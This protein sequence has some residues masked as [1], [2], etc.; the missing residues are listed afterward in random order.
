MLKN[1]HTKF[2][3]KL[4]PGDA[5][6]L[7]APET[8]IFTTD[9]SCL[10]AEPWAVVRPESEAQVVELLKWAQ[11]EKVP[12]FPR[13]RASNGIGGVVPRGGGVVVS[14]LRMNRIVEIGE[15]DFLAVVEPGVVTADLQKAVA[16]RGR[17]YP[18]DPGSVRFSTI[19]GNVAT[20]A[21]GMSAVKYGVTREY[22]LGLTAVLAGG[23]VVRTGGRTHK[24]AMGYDLTKLL[25]GSEG[26][27][28]LFTQV[29]VKLLPLPE[30]S[31]SLLAGFADLGQVLA[32]A[33][34]VFRSGFLPTAMEF[35]D[36]PTLKVLAQVRPVPWSAD[37]GAALLFKLD[38]SEDALAADL[39][40]LTG[41]VRDAG[42]FYLQQGFGPEEEEP[43][44]E[45]RRMISPSM[46]HVAPT[47]MS[48]DIAVPRGRIE[49]AVDAFQA[50][51]RDCGVIVYCFGHLG[52]GNIHVDVMYDEAD[53]A[54]RAAMKKAKHAMY[55]KVLELHGTLT[56][57]HGVGLL[58]KPYVSW[59]LGKAERAL[60]A[61]VKHAF[62][63]LN[64]MN[65]GKGF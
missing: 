1:K 37:V 51:G 38:G 63:P 9:S 19:G 20:G 53:P 58:K 33:R 12:I 46:Y 47:K 4:F 13:A 22:I 55:Q 27:L 29:I 65:P 57:E 7:E 39:K 41:I 28:A 15:D 23:E 16:E 34:S 48:D 35:M 54:Q 17:F 59:Q 14:M 26:T 45:I 36:G 40:K 8:L 43:L 50:I 42:A 2:L 56:G 62:D 21:G 52:D 10:E 5:C 60:M 6:L 3:K 64:I 11:A 61:R 25:V 31:A 44:W 24:D 30:A 18:P 49:E 32:A